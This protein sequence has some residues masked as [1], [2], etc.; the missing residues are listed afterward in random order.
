MLSISR[1]AGLSHTV[2]RRKR[3][4]RSASDA[5]FLLSLQTAESSRVTQF[6]K[7]ALLCPGDMA[8]YTSTDP[9]S[10]D[11]SDDFSQTVVQLPAAKLIDRLP[12]AKCR[13]PGRPHHRRAKRYR[14]VGA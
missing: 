1:V 10:L 12:N 11:L 2:D 8:L 6:G 14:E 4:I 3:D 9:Y 5:Y 7:T 13:K